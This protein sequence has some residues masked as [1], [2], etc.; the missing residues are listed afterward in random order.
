MV[1]EGGWQ[2]A[3]H[4]VQSSCHLVLFKDRILRML[5]IPWLD[6]VIVTS[7]D[8]LPGIWGQ[9][10]W[11]EEGAVIDLVGRFIRFIPGEL[12]GHH[13]SLSVRRD[14]GYG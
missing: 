6:G 7:A 3:S 14:S 4:H 2:G 8:H 12:E 11:E 9:E 5:G 13:R 1:E 10:A